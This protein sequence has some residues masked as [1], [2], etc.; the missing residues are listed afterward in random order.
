MLAILTTYM[1]TMLNL[2]VAD[3]SLGQSNYVKMIAQPQFFSPK[4]CDF[5]DISEPG[6]VME[7]NK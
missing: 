6:L 3:T 7:K 2:G 1:E 4:I 5:C